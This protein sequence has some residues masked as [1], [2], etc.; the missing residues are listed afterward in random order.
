MSI[1]FED[2]EDVSEAALEA[3][4]MKD[5]KS[6]DIAHLREV[7]FW[8]RWEVEHYRSKLDFY[9]G[10]V[11]QAKETMSSVKRKLSRVMEIIC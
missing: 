2:E 11:E 7:V 4:L 3:C 6:Q 5:P 9:E 1:S 10:K 8:L